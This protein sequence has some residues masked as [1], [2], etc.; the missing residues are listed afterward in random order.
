M[1]LLQFA[2]WAALGMAAISSAGAQAPQ[3]DTPSALRGADPYLP[4]ALRKPLRDASTGTALLRYQPMLKLKK[5]FEAADLDGNGVLSRDEARQAGLTVVDKNFDHIDTAQRGAV[6]FD[7]LKA[8]LI[9][10]REE[11]HSR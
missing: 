3:T 10:R 6:S 5:R 9:Q 11:A 4:P 1:K 2:I 8:F 7:D